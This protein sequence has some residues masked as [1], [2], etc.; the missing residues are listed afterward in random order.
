MRPEP[1]PL[2]TLVDT[3]IDYTTDEGFL[4]YEPGEVYS[5]EELVGHL[6]AAAGREPHIQHV[7]LPGRIRVVV[8][9]GGPLAAV[10]LC[11]LIDPGRYRPNQTRSWRPVPAG[12]Y[13][14]E[15]ISFPRLDS[16]WNVSPDRLLPVEEVIQIAAYLAEH[17]DLPDTH[18]WVDALG[19][20]YRRGE[21]GP[22]L[23]LRSP[24]GPPRPPVDDDVPI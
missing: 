22:D 23:G 4:P 6:R 12:R 17:R 21:Y 5:V 8:A 14:T 20:A 9:I 7:D 13:A 18:R 10:Y 19:F 11:P 24:P 15:E 16:E 3:T 1:E 2:C